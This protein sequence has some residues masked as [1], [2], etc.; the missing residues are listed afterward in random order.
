[1]AAEAHS[2]KKHDELKPWFYSKCLEMESRRRRL[3]EW[4]EMN[5]AADLSRAA[6][7]RAE[8]WNFLVDERRR[9]ASCNI[10]KV[11]IQ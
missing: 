3:H 5:S 4:C 8:E 6:A 1:M 7:P 10:P 2:L 11:R 9:L